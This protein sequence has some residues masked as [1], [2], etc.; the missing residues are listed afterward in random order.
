[1]K[2]SNTGGNKRKHDFEVDNDPNAKRQKTDTEPSASVTL[3]NDDL[4][5]K[6]EMIA[7]QREEMKRMRIEIANLKEQLSH[8]NNVLSEKS[9]LQETN[10]AIIEQ[11]R[12]ELGSIKGV[13]PQVAKSDREYKLSL[14]VDRQ[15]DELK[16]ANKKVQELNTA[17]NEAIG[18]NAQ[19]IQV[20]NGQWCIQQ[21]Q[22]GYT[23]QQPQGY[24]QQQLVGY[25]TTTP[26][27]T[28]QPPTA[29][30]VLQNDG[31]TAFQL[32]NNTEAFL[33]PIPNGAHFLANT[34]QMQTDYTAQI[35]YPVMQQQFNGALNVQQEMQNG[36]F[37]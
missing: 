37:I 24:V 25:A 19:L 6:D 27:P 13:R 4:A 29:V 26:P 22:Y 14:L 15:D 1:M 7:V 9:A 23:Q 21:P 17:L 16:E 8:T 18:Q 28:V 35:M 11:L 32:L 34:A 12:A 33:N 30:N 20:L 36:Q 5:H 2:D 31:I 3:K 10:A